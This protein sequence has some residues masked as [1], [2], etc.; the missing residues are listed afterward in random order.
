MCWTIQTFPLNSTG[1]LYSHP[2]SHCVWLPPDRRGKC[3]SARRSDRQFGWHSGCRGGW[4]LRLPCAGW[5]AWPG[6]GRRGQS[7]SQR[8]G[9]QP[10]PGGRDRGPISRKNISI[11]P[12]DWA[13]F[14]SFIFA[15]GHCYWDSIKWRDLWSEHS[16]PTPLRVPVF[17]FA[18]HIWTFT[19]I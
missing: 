14:L 3:G 19:S 1:T 7:S 6:R 10:V 18:T 2:C 13:V 4:A 9:L 17:T 5:G 8:P 11:L 16:F 12:V 15:V